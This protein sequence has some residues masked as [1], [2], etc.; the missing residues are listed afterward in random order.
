MHAF[1]KGAGKFYVMGFHP[2]FKILKRE[3][4]GVNLPCCHYSEKQLKW[5]Y[6]VKVFEFLEININSLKEEGNVVDWKWHRAGRQG[7]CVPVHQL[8]LDAGYFLG[9]NSPG[10]HFSP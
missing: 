7:A 4:L 1:S 10:P 6:N 3:G 2:Q 8:A 9:L 5:S